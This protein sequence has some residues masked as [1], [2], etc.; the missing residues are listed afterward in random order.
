M[1]CTLQQFYTTLAQSFETIIT[2]KHGHSYFDAAYSCRRGSGALTDLAV[3]M[4]WL[5]E[6][7]REVGG[8]VGD[9]PCLSLSIGN[10]PGSTGSARERLG[11][12]G[13]CWLSMGW[14]RY[15]AGSCGGGRLQGCHL[16]A[17]GTASETMVLM[18]S[19]L[20]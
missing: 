14:A 9:R 19:E 8:G 17:S 6:L 4:Q 18:F 11:A 1:L 5:R 12:L 10:S 13:V 3:V 16:A 20:G 7:A 2:G 15:V